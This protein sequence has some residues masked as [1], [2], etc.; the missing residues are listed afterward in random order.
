VTLDDIHALEEHFRRAL[1]IPVFLEAAR[2]DAAPRRLWQGLSAETA[3]FGDP[4]RAASWT[5]GRAALECLL[6]RLAVDGPAGAVGFPHPFLSLTHTGD[7]AIAAGTAPGAA[8]GIGVDLE[9][10]TGMRE[11]AE[12]FFL[13]AEETAWLLA[14]PRESRGRERVRLWTVKEA[15]YKANPRNEGTLLGHYLLEEP[16]TSAGTAR[17]KD[18]PA[19]RYLYASVAL[20][21]GALS[22]AVTPRAR[23]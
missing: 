21:P 5:R 13:C 9:M 2:G 15:L 22:L 3:R 11:G 23:A 7:W 14:R 18:D 19:A 16:G 1:G 17:G 4:A 8:L 20:D 10:R 12:R 6:E